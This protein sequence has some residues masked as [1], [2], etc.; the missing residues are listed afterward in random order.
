MFDMAEK[1]KQTGQAFVIYHHTAGD[2]IDHPAEKMK[3]YL[4]QA[5]AYLWGEAAVSKERLSDY[6]TMTHSILI[7]AQI[8]KKIRRFWMKFTEEFFSQDHEKNL[9]FDVLKN[10]CLAM[11]SQAPST[12]MLTPKNLAASLMSEIDPMEP[13]TFKQTASSYEYLKHQGYLEQLDWYWDNPTIPFPRN[14]AYKG[15]FRP[16]EKFWYDNIQ[17]GTTLQDIEEA[18]F[19]KG[20]WIDKPLGLHGYSDSGKLLSEICPGLLVAVNLPCGCLNKTRTEAERM[21]VQGAIIHLNDKNVHNGVEKEWTR[22]EIADWLESLDV[23]LTLK[24]Q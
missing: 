22:E 11:D 19:A 7:D 9:F 10:M 15:G 2:F 13:V 3:N 21:S 8:N 20:G 23:D 18:Q 17:N 1:A 6:S 16:V 4:A 12:Y 5:A 24:G 14:L